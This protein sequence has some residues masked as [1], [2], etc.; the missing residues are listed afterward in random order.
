M[1]AFQAHLAGWQTHGIG[2]FDRDAARQALAVPEDHALHA[3]VA[4]G[5]HGDKALLP[6]ALQARERPNDRLPLKTLIAEGRF[7]FDD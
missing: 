4:I 7:A 6:E 5:R 1:L 3:V 2:G